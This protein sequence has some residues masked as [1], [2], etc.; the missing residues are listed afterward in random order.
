MD[1][2]S[3]IGLAAN[4][5]QFIDFGCQLFRDTKE[6]HRSTQGTTNENVEL[7]DI[8][9]SLSRLSQDLSA[10]VPDSQSPYFQIEKEIRTLALQSKS[11]ADE[12]IATIPF[13]DPN[14]TSHR[15]WR[16]FLQAI[17]TVWDKSKISTLRQRLDNIRNILSTQ[18]L[19][20]VR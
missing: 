16:S 6:I 11:I 5:L 13:L 3:A 4:I 7:R 19:A 14:A 1:P 8:T 9:Q 17:H 15:R 18:L 20:L 10:P 12:L 2:L